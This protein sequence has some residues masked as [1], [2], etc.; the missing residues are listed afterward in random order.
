MKTWTGTK[1]E[2]GIE[3]GAD[4]GAGAGTDADAVLALAAL[5]LAEPDPAEAP[6]TRAELLRAGAFAVPAVQR[7][8][9][10]ARQAARRF[11][12]G[13]AGVDPAVVTA[14]YQCPECGAAATQSHGVPRY[15][16]RGR[17]VPFQVSFSRSGQWLL[18]GATA[19][20]PLGVD[21]ADLAG[22]GDPR[23][24]AVIA[25]D[26]EQARYDVVA[27]ASRALRQARLWTRKEAVLKA[28]GD[29]LRTAPHLIEVGLEAGTDSTVAVGPAG[30]RV[31]I[32]DL[33]TRM[34]GLPT[35]LLAAAALPAAGGLRIERRR[36]N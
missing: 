10:A 30:D 6:L 3:P 36:W 12:A 4:D 17:A 9:L 27:P 23:L 18:A 20:G 7:R 34:L 1:T 15:Q 22:F 5:Q 25:T 24:D 26:A 31:S 29:G 19:A 16:V 2:A 8:F 14:D 28:S 11:V 21:L 13:L 35:G 33:D 32:I